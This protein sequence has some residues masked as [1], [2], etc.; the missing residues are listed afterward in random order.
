MTERLATLCLCQAFVHFVQE[1]I[2]VVHHPLDC[3]LSQHL[4]LHFAFARDAR[5]L[6]LQ[7]G[8]EVGAR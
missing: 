4:G 5:E 2:V 3:F 6:G 1:P 7:I 8:R